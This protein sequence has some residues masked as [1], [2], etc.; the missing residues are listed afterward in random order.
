M[1][2][3][4]QKP[5]VATDA[6]PPSTTPMAPC[7]DESPRISRWYTI[8]CAQP[9]VGVYCEPTSPDM[10]S[11]AQPPLARGRLQT[12]PMSRPSL[13]PPERPSGLPWASSRLSPSDSRS[14]RDR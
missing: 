2:S 3:A 12:T 11:T 6:S 9:A 14:G 8:D 13:K 5:L 10:G 1:V 7:H 4:D